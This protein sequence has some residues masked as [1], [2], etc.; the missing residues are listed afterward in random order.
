LAWACARCNDYKGSDVSAYVPESNRLVRLYNP[1]IDVWDEHFLWEGSKLKGI[2]EIASAT[3]KLLRLNADHRI[4]LRQA[5][6]EEG[7]F[8]AQDTIR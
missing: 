7:L 1:R 8:F 4:I 3:I 6:M 5:L 2:S